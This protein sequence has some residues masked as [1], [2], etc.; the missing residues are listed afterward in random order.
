MKKKWLLP[1][2]ASL[3]VVSA[4]SFASAQATTETQ[5]TTTAKSYLDTP[6]G[7]GGTTRASIDCSGFTM[8]V[9]KELGVSLERTS[10][11]QY[12]QG[13]AV[14]K[15]D[16]QVGDLVFFNTSGRGVSHVGIYIGNGNMIS[17]ESSEG[18]A[19][20]SINDPYYWGPR[21]IGAKRVTTFASVKDA[22]IDFSVH[23]SRG[24]VANQLAAALNLDTSKTDT[25]FADV[26][27]THKYAGAI[28]AVK[29]AGIF[30]G[31]KE[32]KFNPNSP[33]T[34]AQVAQVLVQAFDFEKGAYDKTFSDIS[35]NHPAAD[36]IYTLASNGIISGKADGTY[37]ANDI[38]TL[39][40][41]EAFITRAK[42]VA[43]Q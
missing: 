5:L 35:A 34:R 41:L 29:E 2:F 20:S 19:I 15:S 8:S 23:A 24:E 13:K 39:K 4:P 31:D 27:S 9:F 14:A 38:V 3:M 17:A 25:G 42:G 10:S 26:K 22:A 40:Q 11:G 36:A 33:M 7:L 32:G 43:N 1:V 21:Y 6:Y 16:L 28:N 30:A 12:S 18:V 37:G